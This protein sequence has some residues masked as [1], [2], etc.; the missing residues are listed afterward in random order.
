MFS[1]TNSWYVR[2]VNGPMDG[3]V[4]QLVDHRPQVALRRTGKIK[5][6]KKSFHRKLSG[7]SCLKV[8]LSFNTPTL[9]ELAFFG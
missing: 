2:L 4:G 1:S 7:M 9:I 6:N 3:S 5:E 8:L